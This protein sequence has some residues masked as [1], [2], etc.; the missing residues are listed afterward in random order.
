MITI[1]NRAELF[2]D[3]NQEAAA[4]V[5]S[6]LKANGIEYEM[7]TKQDVSTLRKNIHY[8]QG[9]NGD[10]RVVFWGCADVY[11]SDLCEEEGFGEGEGGVRAVRGVGKYFDAS[12]IYR[13]AVSEGR[14]PPCFIG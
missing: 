3:V 8:S 6:T 4:K 14:Q 5:W 10:S 9:M 1:F 7:S 2:T 13:G 11:L 12:M